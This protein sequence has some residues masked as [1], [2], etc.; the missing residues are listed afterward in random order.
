MTRTQAERRATT[1]AKVLDATVEALVAVGYAGTSTTEICR[2][3]GLSQGSLFRYWPTKGELL[4]DAAAHVL[5]RV[6]TAYEQAFTGRVGA[7]EALEALW[8]T[9]R[10][11]DLQAAVE[12]YVAARTDP[13]LATALARIEP[14]HRANLHRIALS[15]LDERLV[16]LP[17]FGAFVELAL[18]AVQ[19]A[20]MSA[21][22]VDTSHDVVL[23]AL[24][25]VVSLL[26]P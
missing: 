11:P 25:Q 9:Y 6:T 2:R 14:A 16:A 3:A 4:A 22:V 10:L 12:L 20:A 24:E 5:A 13:E 7:R 15:V 23:G 17:G 21:A 1:Q 26:D 8:D 19:G 18:A